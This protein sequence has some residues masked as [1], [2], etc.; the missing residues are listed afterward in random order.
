MK[1]EARSLLRLIEAARRAPSPPPSGEVSAGWV[2]GLLRARLSRG[3][4]GESLWVVW[5]RLT[6][7]AAALATGAA[8]AVGWALPPAAAS[9]D[10]AAAWQRQ[11]EEWVYL[12]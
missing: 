2:E 6:P 11:V 1:P 12:P 7:W 4:E 3:R 8:I 10:D 5:S 9:G